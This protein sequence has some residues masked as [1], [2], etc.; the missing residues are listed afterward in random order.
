MHHKLL[1]RQLS[2]SSLHSTE[3]KTHVQM[4]CMLKTRAHVSHMPGKP[5]VYNFIGVRP[6]FITLCGSFHWL[7][8][9]IARCVSAVILIEPGC[10]ITQP[11][12]Q[13]SEFRWK[14][15]GR[16]EIISHG[17]ALCLIVNGVSSYFPADC[18]FFFSNTRKRY[19]FSDSCKVKKWRCFSEI[20]C[21]KCLW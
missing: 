13:Q 12:D 17:T 7:C 16:A 20:L 14:D 10:S 5:S 6:P 2:S 19:R 15:E 9:L 3:N 11:K 8:I 18:R 21:N 4:K 1:K